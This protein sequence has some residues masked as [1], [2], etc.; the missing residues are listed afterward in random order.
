MKSKL[1]IFTISIFFHINSHEHSCIAFSPNDKYIVITDKSI[2]KVFSL[3]KIEK[4]CWKGLFDT[5]SPLY[6]FDLGE[7]ILS[8]AFSSEGKYLVTTGAKKS[9]LWEVPLGVKIARLN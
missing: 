2:A 6:K 8:L 5:L 4:E 3:E 1:I 7:Q 9:I